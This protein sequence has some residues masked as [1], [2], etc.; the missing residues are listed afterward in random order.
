MC[1]GGEEF[2]IVFPL[3]VFASSPLP[4]DRTL[5]FSFFLLAAVCAIRLW[6]RCRVY[7]KMARRSGRQVKG[8]RAS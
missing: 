6:N 8:A 1:V 7:E 4:S 3:T 2:V 5:L